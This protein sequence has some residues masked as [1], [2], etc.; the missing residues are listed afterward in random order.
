M[1][2]ESLSF[3]NKFILFNSSS[4]NFAVGVS[5]GKIITYDT[6]KLTQKNTFYLDVK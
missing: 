2:V 3:F 1:E 5:D 6:A 4:L